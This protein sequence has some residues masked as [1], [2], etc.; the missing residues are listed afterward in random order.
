MNLDDDEGDRQVS[1]L[2]SVFHGL[3]RQALILREERLFAEQQRRA[4]M[5]RLADTLKHVWL[6]KFV[7]QNIEERV[8]TIW[9]GTSAY[10][11]Y[12]GLVRNSLEALVC[13]G[14]CRKGDRP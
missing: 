3:Y 10:C 13:T 8:N 14:S 9:P 1:D 11:A 5:R 7:R 4:C 6:I 2:E 12:C